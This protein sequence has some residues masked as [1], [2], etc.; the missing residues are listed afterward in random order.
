MSMVW[1]VCDHLKS[2]QIM[3]EVRK[4]RMMDV[5]VVA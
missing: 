2:R 3:F 4:I 1:I 5:T